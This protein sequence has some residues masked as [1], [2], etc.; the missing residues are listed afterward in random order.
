MTQTE[1]NQEVTKMTDN[2]AA[3]YY[4]NYVLGCKLICMRF[5][6]YLYNKKV[7][8]IALLDNIAILVVQVNF[9]TS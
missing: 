5:I 1:S 8:S 4:E 2:H 6:N 7:R 3:G 9:H